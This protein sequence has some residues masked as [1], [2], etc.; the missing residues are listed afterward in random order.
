MKSFIGGILDKKSLPLAPTRDDW[1]FG[2][3]LSSGNSSTDR[4][5]Q[6]S[7][8]GSVGAVFAI[9]NQECNPLAALRW[10]LFQKDDG[11]P[12]V[13]VPEATRVLRMDHAAAQLWENP[14]PLM[15]R[16][17]LMTRVQQHR[18]LTGEGWLF[19]AR[20]KYFSEPKELWPIPPDRIDVIPHKTKYIAGYVYTPPESDPIPLGVNDVMHIHTPDPQNLLRGIGP[21]Q[22]IM[23]DLEGSQLTAEWNRNFFLNSA[24]PGGIIQVDKRMDDVEFNTFRQRWEDQH[25]GTANAHRAAVLTEAKWVE[26]GRAHV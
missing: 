10:G 25:K 11:N 26:I 12:F 21:V 18:E 16:K 20:D 4:T 13:K 15:T 8:Y 22:T 19:V 9:V 7:M 1:G 6:L 3:L 2:G 17:E 24:R 14:N 5:T 23:A